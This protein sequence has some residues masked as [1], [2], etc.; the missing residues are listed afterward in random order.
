MSTYDP[1]AHSLCPYG[2]NGTGCRYCG[3]QGE[4][5]H[6]DTW[7]SDRGRYVGLPSRTFW[8]GVL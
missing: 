4:L 2:C 1:T 5:G 3:G 6:S 7:G 8:V